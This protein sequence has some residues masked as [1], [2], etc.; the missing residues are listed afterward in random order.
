[1]AG[2]HAMPQVA[3]KIFLS[4]AEQESAFRLPP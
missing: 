4:F 2:A 1:M 3:V